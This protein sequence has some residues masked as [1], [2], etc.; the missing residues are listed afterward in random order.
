MN[1]VLQSAMPAAIAT[2]NRTP[3]VLK[4]K[5]TQLVNLRRK[6]FDVMADM[7][8]AVF[9]SEMKDHLQVFGYSPQAIENEMR[10]MYKGEML[11]RTKLRPYAYT[12]VKGA[13]QPSDEVVKVRCYNKAAPVTAVVID[14]VN[15]LPTMAKLNSHI[16]ALA[17]IGRAHQ[18][19][20]YGYLGADID[21][22]TNHLSKLRSDCNKTGNVDPDV[23]AEYGL[24][25]QNL[26]LMVE[27]MKQLEANILRISQLA[28]VIRSNPI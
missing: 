1:P 9:P 5:P 6:I 19:Q 21:L 13:T 11:T 10:E 16:D 7:D 24:M 27:H 17:A 4:V 25:G 23:A 8:E 2:A 15:A 14:N 22:V 18:L 20:Q 3:A 26:E 28:K 12:L